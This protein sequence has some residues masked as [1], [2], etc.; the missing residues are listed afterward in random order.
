[1]HMILIMNSSLIA[2]PALSPHELTLE[3]AILSNYTTGITGLIT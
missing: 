3:S 2:T 1:M